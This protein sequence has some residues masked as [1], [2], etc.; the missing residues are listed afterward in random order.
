MTSIRVKEN[1][2]V[3]GS[4]PFLA[5]NHPPDNERLTTSRKTHRFSLLQIL[6]HPREPVRHELPPPFCV[7]KTCP[8]SHPTA[9]RESVFGERLGNGAHSLQDLPEADW[10]EFP[11][12][13]AHVHALP[14]RRQVA[15]TVTVTMYSSVFSPT[16]CSG[17]PSNASNPS[18]TRTEPMNNAAGQC[19]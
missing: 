16:T 4:I 6:W 14:E 19:R 7:A 8:R 9:W 15:V 13:H 1:P 5:T 12:V 18:L 3:G 10:P 11:G 17:M 2:C